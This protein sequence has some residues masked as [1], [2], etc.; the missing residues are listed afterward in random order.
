MSEKK[1]LYS[2]HS[3]SLNIEYCLNIETISLLLNILES[4]AYCVNINKSCIF[5]T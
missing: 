3:R 4:Q 1:H 2:K 5:L